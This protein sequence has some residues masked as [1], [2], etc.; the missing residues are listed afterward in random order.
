MM[1]ALFGWDGTPDPPD[2]ATVEGS[3]PEGVLAS[4]SSE[5]NPS[6]N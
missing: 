2:T 6:G 1:K 3:P 5:E 4:L